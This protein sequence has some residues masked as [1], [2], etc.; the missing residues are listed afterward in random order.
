MAETVSGEEKVP[1]IINMPVM[2]DAGLVGA[3]LYSTV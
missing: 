3:I 2:D 1:S